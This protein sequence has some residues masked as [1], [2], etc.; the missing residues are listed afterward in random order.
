VEGDG[1][2]TLVQVKHSHNPH[3]ARTESRYVLK[4]KSTKRSSEKAI[5]RREAIASFSLLVPPRAFSFFPLARF[6]R[7]RRTDRFRIAKLSLR[8]L[9]ALLDSDLASP[10]FATSI[11]PSPAPYSRYGYEEVH[12]DTGGP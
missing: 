9:V 10:R 3:N 8:P 5:G 7:F 1:A 6:T 12:K 4:T 2:A 11:G